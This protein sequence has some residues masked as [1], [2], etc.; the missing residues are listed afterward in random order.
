[1]PTLEETFT[2]IAKKFIAGDFDAVCAYFDMPI[3]I[4]AGERVV[5]CPSQARFIETM[6]RYHQL[7]TD[8]GIADVSV[9]VIALPMMRGTTGTIW[10]EKTYFDAQGTRVDSC[11][12]RY[13]FRRVYGQ[14]RVCMLE[15]VSRPAAVENAEFG[16][17]SAA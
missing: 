12:V 3:A 5:I 7:L 10:V 15:Y 13:F 1:M 2:S 16:Y 9:N 14:T 4:Y 8:A 17:F 11:Q 6:R